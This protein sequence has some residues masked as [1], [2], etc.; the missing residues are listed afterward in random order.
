MATPL[1]LY[2]DVTL[3]SFEARK[4]MKLISY[5]TIEL[6]T[7]LV[8]SQLPYLWV[9]TLKLA[10]PK[11]HELRSLNPLLHSYC[12]ITSFVRALPS[13]NSL[14]LSSVVRAMLCMA[15]AVKKA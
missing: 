11:A 1:F 8:N 10:Y 14:M 7:E 13:L 5:S 9:F 2:W 6:F 12:S 3:S 15:S 4:F